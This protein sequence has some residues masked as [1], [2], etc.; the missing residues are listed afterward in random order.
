MQIECVCV[1]VKAARLEA[2]A[3][4]FLT[5]MA[6]EAFGRSARRARL[7]WVLAEDIFHNIQRAW[8]ETAVIVFTAY[9]AA[10]A[11]EMEIVAR[12]M[13]F[14]AASIDFPRIV[15][16]DRTVCVNAISGQVYGDIILPHRIEVGDKL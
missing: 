9:I 5:E 4:L 14:G 12:L 11:T 2:P 3:S 8:I 6:E 16:R 13:D 10:F 15:G 7:T 1:S